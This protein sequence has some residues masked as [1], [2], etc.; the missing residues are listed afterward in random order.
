MKSDLN[1]AQKDAKE[2]RDISAANET[3]LAELTAT[4]DKYKADIDAV[5]AKLEVRNVTSC[6]RFF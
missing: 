6:G 4:Y 1:A 5:T 3:A 2:Y